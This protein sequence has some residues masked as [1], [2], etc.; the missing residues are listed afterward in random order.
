MS[1]SRQTNAPSVPDADLRIV[2]SKVGTTTTIGL[3]GEWELA[4]QIAARE[5]IGRALACRPECLVLDLSRLKFIDSSGVQAMTSLVTRTDRLN[6]R[7]S[8]LPA[9]KSVHRIFEICHLT[10]RLPFT[11]A[12]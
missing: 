11:S 12:S 3:A 10:D 9:P 4:T 7:L 6:V 5:A 2:V 8:I 1:A